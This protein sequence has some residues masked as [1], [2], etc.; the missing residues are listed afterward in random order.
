MC[1]LT[2]EIKLSQKNYD[3]VLFRTS[4]YLC[5][6]TTLHVCTSKNTVLLVTEFIHDKTDSFGINSVYITAEVHFLYVINYCEADRLKS[7]APGWIM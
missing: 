1:F 6:C 5:V 4:S 3:I 2:P 7:V